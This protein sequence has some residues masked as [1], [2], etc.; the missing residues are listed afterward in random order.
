MPERV[1]TTDPDGVD[2]AW[3]MQATF[4]LTIVFGAPIVAL[5]SVPVTLST[6]GARVSFAIRVGA[7]VWLVVAV[8]AFLYA[9]RSA[10]GRTR[11]RAGSDGER[12]RTGDAERTPASHRTGDDRG[13]RSDRDGRDDRND[14]SDPDESEGSDDPDDAEEGL[15][16]A[17]PADTHSSPERRSDT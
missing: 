8:G 10:D 5:A 2:F 9:R 13:D 15:Q 12:E 11:E 3:V 14:R 16:S 4:V 1:E 6:W 17:T 7:I